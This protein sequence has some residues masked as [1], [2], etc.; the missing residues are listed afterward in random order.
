MFRRRKLFGLK[1][2]HFIDD[3]TFLNS[4]YDIHFSRFLISFKPDE[5]VRGTNILAQ[6]QTHIVLFL[7]I[8]S[9]L[10]IKQFPSLA[11]LFKQIQ[12]NHNQSNH[13]SR[14]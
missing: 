1:I 3:K 4:D 7:H 12:L 10:M 8:Y 11:K 2:E 13:H 14:A 5:Q 9:F 6:T